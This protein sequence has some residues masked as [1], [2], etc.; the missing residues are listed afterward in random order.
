MTGSG[1][2]SDSKAASITVTSVSVG[3]LVAGVTVAGAGVTP[4][5]VG[6][7]GLV[8]MDG[9]Y[10]VRGN[11]GGVNVYNRTD[12]PT[13][14]PDND[15][16]HGTSYSIFNFSA[17]PQ[18]HMADSEDSGAYVGSNPL[19]VAFPWQD[20]WQENDA[21]PPIPTVTRNDVAAEENWQL[22]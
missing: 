19:A 6:G 4:V 13:A 12:K 22:V 11:W 1:E 15:F 5:D 8:E 20:T 17:G 3:E 18:W 16:G 10:N 7:T 2:T 21:L 9:A 14:L